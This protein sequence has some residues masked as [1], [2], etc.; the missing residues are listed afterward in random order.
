MQKKEGKLKWGLYNF[1]GPIISLLVFLV[2]FYIDPL[3]FGKEQPLAT[4]PAFFL[5]LLVLIINQ[6]IN[7]SKEIQKTNQYSD[8]IYE[9]IKDYLHVTPIGNPEKAFDYIISRLPA[10]REVKNTS[11][12]IKN[13]ME[14]ADEKFYDTEVYRKSGEK[15][16]FYS[17][18]GNDMEGYWR[19]VCRITFQ[20][21]CKECRK[22]IKE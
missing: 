21:Y 13:E 5:A 20:R 3:N 2:S 9:A 17:T 7:T 18:K 14:R 19:F 12:N 15:I 16:A 4:L 22:F 6:N 11:F 8:V 10:L 1:L